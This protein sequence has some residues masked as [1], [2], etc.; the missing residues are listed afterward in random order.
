[1]GQSGRQGHFCLFTHPNHTI[2]EVCVF[3]CIHGSQMAEHVCVSR[4]SLPRHKH[5]FHCYIRIYPKNLVHIGATSPGTQPPYPCTC[6]HF[7][8][9]DPACRVLEDR[10]QA[11]CVATTRALGRPQQG[12]AV[13]DDPVPRLLA[14]RGRDGAPACRGGRGM[15][16]LGSGYGIVRAR[17]WKS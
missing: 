13:R 15:G 8:P 17:V 2:Y 10:H 7:A 5:I 11:G 4:I 6:T 14:A 12:P 16:Q 3:T 1:M 9:L